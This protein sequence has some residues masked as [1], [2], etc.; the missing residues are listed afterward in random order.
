MIGRDGAIVGEYGR[1]FDR[2]ATIYDLWQAGV[3]GD[4]R[5]TAAL[6]DRPTH[7]PE[8]PGGALRRS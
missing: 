1:R 8:C 6:L 2:G 5:M 3:L 7:Q 4:A